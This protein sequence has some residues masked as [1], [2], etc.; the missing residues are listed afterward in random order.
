MDEIKNLIELV[1]YYKKNKDYLNLVKTKWQLYKLYVFIYGSNHQIT[2]SCLNNVKENCINISKIF[3][4][5]ARD[6]RKVGQSK[7]ALEYA[8]KCYELRAE[9]LG[10]SHPDTLISLNNL[11]VEYNTLGQYKKAFEHDQKC[12]ELRK[13]VYDND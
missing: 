13:E 4:I 1:N 3:F 11:A 12:Y 7:K 2:L 9:I 10:E 5:H 6:Y 8:Q